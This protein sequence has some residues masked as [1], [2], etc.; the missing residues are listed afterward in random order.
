MRTLLISVFAFSCPAQAATLPLSCDNE[1]G[2]VHLELEV[3]ES[4]VESFRLRLADGEPA[5]LTDTSFTSG[6]TLWGGLPEGGYGNYW[7]FPYGVYAGRSQRAQWLLT[8]GRE[9]VMGG[10]GYTHEGILT[11]IQGAEVA[12]QAVFCRSW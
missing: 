5:L 6:R 9:A 11:S 8:V 7:V 3:G 12:S 1:T 10:G 2:T 4:A